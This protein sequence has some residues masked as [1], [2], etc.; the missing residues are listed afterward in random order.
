MHQK[1]Q[2][3]LLEHPDLRR[4]INDRIV[5]P[6]Y[7]RTRSDWQGTSYVIFAM[8]KSFNYQ[9]TSSI[10]SFDHSSL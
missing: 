1:A 7:Y 2:R 9:V 8:E 4:S 10:H 3:E 6:G 5:V